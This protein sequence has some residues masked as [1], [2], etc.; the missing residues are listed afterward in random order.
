[1][2]RLSSHS[3]NDSDDNSDSSS[4]CSPSSDDYSDNVLIFSIKLF[5]R[6]LNIFSQMVYRNL[7]IRRFWDQIRIL[8]EIL[9]RILSPEVTIES[10]ALSSVTES[11]NH[12]TIQ[13]GTTIRS[14]IEIIAHILTTDIRE[15]ILT[16][17]LAKSILHLLIGKTLIDFKCWF[18][19]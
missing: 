10:P 5:Y 4:M 3:M 15:E 11:P 19:G 13:N 7:K 2:L 16:K 9:R 6:K 1:M 18:Q 12:K 17:I 14:P 8:R